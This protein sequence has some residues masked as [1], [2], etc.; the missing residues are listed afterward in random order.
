M[1]EWVIKHR[2]TEVEEPLWIGETYRPSRR[3]WRG[4]AWGLLFSSILWGGV[5]WYVFG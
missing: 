1:S 2:G 5:V 3:F 4:M